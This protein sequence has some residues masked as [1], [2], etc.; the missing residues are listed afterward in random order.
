MVQNIRL[1]S[2]LT[3]GLVGY[4]PL[5]EGGGGTAF[6]R[7]VYGKNG[8]LVGN[9][10]SVVSDRG[11]VMSFDG[12]GD[13]ISVGHDESLI[14]ADYS[15][16]F[17]VRTSNTN[18][19]KMV[20]TKASTVDNRSIYIYFSTSN[21]GINAI[22]S[23]TI[24]GSTDGIVSSSSLQNDTWYYVNVV[25][26][27]KTSL[28]LYINAEL[29]GSDYAIAGDL[30]TNTVPLRFGAR[31]D[32]S[33]YFDG[34]LS[35]ISLHNR[36]L[37][38]SEIQQ[39]YLHGLQSRRDPIELWA[40]ATAGGGGTSYQDEVNVQTSVQSSATDTAVLNDDVSVSTT[41]SASVTDISAFTDDINSTV[42]TSSS[43]D[44]VYTPNGAT[45]YF[46]E[47][48]VSVT[49]GS[50]VVDTLTVTDDVSV[51]VSTTSEITDMYGFVDEVNCSTSIDCEVTD[52]LAYSDDVTATVTVSDSATDGVSFYDAVNTQCNVQCEASDSYTPISGFLVSAAFLMLKKHR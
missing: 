37:T 11:R 17:W 12:S 36:A 30:Y 39:L 50:S 46:D 15:I 9:T 5:D 32:S 24:G 3:T 34:E 38:A 29:D 25:L 40:A 43:V 44:D 48:N 19:V 33:Y 16:S 23:G 13:Y 2:E 52:T 10:H 31:Y 47:V 4:W 35:D 49:C 6:D 8:T 20:A 45:A 14:F 22:V 26:I 41:I 27:N 28:L 21:Q 18:Q 7:S 1:G 42:T 51:S